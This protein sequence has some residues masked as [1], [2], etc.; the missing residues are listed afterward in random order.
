LNIGAVDAVGMNP[1]IA[2]TVAAAVAAWICSAG[3]YVPPE[4]RRRKRRSTRQDPRG[5]DTPELF[6]EDTAT[7][8]S[9][10][11]NNTSSESKH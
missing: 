11:N 3:R 5:Y 6:D 9:V 10:A 1:I 4:G 2:I 7:R 8:L